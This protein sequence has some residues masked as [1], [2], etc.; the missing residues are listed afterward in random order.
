MRCP[1]LFELESVLS[2]GALLDTSSS[3][4]YDIVIRHPAE[5]AERRARGLLKIS[6]DNTKVIRESLRAKWRGILSELSVQ[7]RA[8]AGT[9][10]QSAQKRRQ[11]FTDGSD[12]NGNTKRQVKNRQVLILKD[13][14]PMA[15]K[16]CFRWMKPL[17]AFY[18]ILRG[19]WQWIWGSR[20][21]SL[22]QSLKTAYCLYLLT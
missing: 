20:S 22:T 11:C 14:E 17:A 16:L 8:H 1:E 6:R 7:A 4:D 10:I 3:S 13:R 2:S 12:S 9:I 15:I 5:I 19:L 18:F 21:C